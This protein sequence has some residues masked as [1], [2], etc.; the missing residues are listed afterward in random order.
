MGVTM[1]PPE[2]MT[3][4]AIKAV[5]IHYAHLQDINAN[6]AECFISP[7]TRKVI[8]DD[9]TG[10]LRV[11][12]PTLWEV[13]IFPQSQSISTGRGIAVQV[14]Y[15]DGGVEATAFWPIP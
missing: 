1:Q 3:D 8:I 10:E 4:A 7:T 9:D 14:E 12:P 13:R 2:E 5:A 6:E 15:H 11:I